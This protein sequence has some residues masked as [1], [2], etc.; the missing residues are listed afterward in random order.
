MAAHFTLKKER[1]FS[2]LL[3]NNLNI[4]RLNKQFRN[5]NKA[6]FKTL[7]DDLNIDPKL[8]EKVYEFATE[9]LNSFLHVNMFNGK[10]KYFKKFVRINIE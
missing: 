3:S 6:D 1:S 4:K 7:E 10:P 2:L 8:L 5:N 9:E